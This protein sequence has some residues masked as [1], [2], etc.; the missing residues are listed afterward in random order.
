M[1]TPARALVAPLLLAA[2]AVGCSHT[3]AAAPPDTLERAAAAATQ[4]GATQ[5]RTLALAGFHAWLLGGDAAAAQAR[6]NAALEKDPAEP[7]ALLGQVQL[8]RREGAPHRALEAALALCTRV[9]AHPL[10]VVAARYVQDAVGN[11]PAVDDEVLRGTEAALKAG[12]RG[13]AALLLRSARLA[14]FSLRGDE[15][16]RARARAEMGVV[17]TA[18]LLG[19]LSAYHVLGFEQPTPPETSGAVGGE[20]KGPLGPVAPR[21]LRALDGRL[22][23]SG[24]PSLGD[25]Y[26]LAVD[27]EVP[28]GGLYLART[29][30]TTTH[31]LLVDGRTVLE[32]QALTRAASTITAR[33][34]HLSAGR[35]RLLLKVQRGQRYGQVALML[36]RADGRPAQ[37]RYTPAT[38]S[39]PAGWSLGAASSESPVPHAYPTAEDMARELAAEVGQ[40]LGDFIAARDG[41]QRDLDGVWRLMARLEKAAPQ[42]AAV[43][44]LR[45]ELA[46][47]DRT[48]PSRVSRGRVTRDL[49]AALGRDGGD[50]AALLMRAELALGDEQPQAALD[51]ARAARE[52]SAEAGWPLGLVEARALLALGLVGPAEEKLGELL[53]RWPG[54]CQ[55]LELRYSQAQRR[56]AVGQADELVGALERC[57]GGLS[58]S[59]EHARTRGNLERAAAL[60]E[61][62]AA[63]EPGSVGIGE[64]LARVYLSLRRHE[65]AARVLR[66]LLELWPRQARLLKQLADV[67]EHAGDPAEALRLREQALALEGNDLALLRAVSRARTGQEPLQAYA[68]DGRKAIAEYE[69]ARGA[70]DSTAA[71]VLDAAAV[72]VLPDGSQLSRVH[73]IQK[74]L[75]QNGVEEVAEVEVPSGAQVLALRTIK[76]DGTVL[77]PESIAHKDTVSLPGVQVGDYVEL[78]YLEVSP[79]RGPV[80]P[81]FKA[82]PFY[83]QIAN[84]PNYRSR[85]TVVAPK[86]TG[87]RVDAHGVKVQPPRVE[88]EWEVFTHEERQVAP[89]IPEPDAPQSANEYLPFVIVG[90]GTTGN[91]RLVEAYADAYLERGQVTWEVEA[92]AREVAGERRGLEAVKAVHAAVMKRIRGRDGGLSQSAASTLAQERGSRLWLMKAALEAL[93]Y[94]ARLAAVRA[95]AADPA[96]YVFPEEALLPYIGLR[97]EVPGVGPVWVD[98][99]VRNGPFG[100]LPES[101]LGEREAYLMPEPGRPLERVKTPPYEAPEGKQVVLKLSLDEQGTLSGEGQEVY[102]GLEGARLAEAFE[103][104]SEDRRKQALEG[105]VG[106]YFGEAELKSVSV[107]STGEVGAPFG[108]KYAFSAPRFVRPEGE[109]RVLRPLTLPALLG[110]QH[111]QLSKRGTPLYMNDTEAS[112]V[113]VE[114][115]LPEGWRLADPQAKL[116]VKGPF[117][118]LVRSER[119]EG[120]RLVIE[121]SLRVRQGRIQPEQY[122]AFAEFAGE[123]DLLQSRDLTLVRQAPSAP[124]VR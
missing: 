14:I 22:E 10:A 78:E 45:A 98:A 4:G 59:A 18:T 44:S 92:F 32:R 58:R 9:P 40:V 118:E 7:Y 100:K 55:A 43:L 116:E 70:E 64:S 33:P 97:V 75:D 93:G 77:E 67:R 48:V 122:E 29:T 121:E 42:S 28:E 25:V 79:A 109:R 1:R 110:R 53:K 16:G 17:D 57:P 94:P 111:V 90:A 84:M 74:A 71:Y 54:L 115:E 19:P 72:Q 50:V 38:A 68:I 96:P 49:E 117:G 66:G 11:S 41:L 62:L 105:A 114:L 24:E 2:V 89:F 47:Q 13:E 34:L 101:A 5:A 52:A 87:M 60:L 83:F 56:D 65:E 124:P 46:S 106:R 91:D 35:H 81:G 95:F 15:E 8:A 103:A 23:L 108:V 99:A 27:A 12:A 6:F 104:M 20:L 3:R 85:Y 120:R 123:V 73:I 36:A 113:R 112:R 21:T 61:R 26:L 69:A 119:Q 107:E 37:V 63:S 102:T 51:T 31:R 88:G 39:A 76:A 80:Q 86:G 30:S 82:S